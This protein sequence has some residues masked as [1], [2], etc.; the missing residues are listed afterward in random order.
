MIDRWA[1]DGVITPSGKGGTFEAKR[2][3]LSGVDLGQVGARWSSE[4]STVAIGFGATDL[5]LSSF[6]VPDRLGAMRA[7]ESFQAYAARVVPRLTAEDWRRTAGLLNEKGAALRGAVGVLLLGGLVGCWVRYRDEVRR[8][9][10]NFIQ[11]GKAAQSR[12]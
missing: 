8:W 3:T 11:E 6:P 2:A 9:W 5:V 12:S 4:Q 7:G 10:R 1:E